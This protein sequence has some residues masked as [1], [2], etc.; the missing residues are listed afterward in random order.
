MKRTIFYIGLLLPLIGVGQANLNLNNLNL[1]NTGCGYYG[2]TSINFTGTTTLVSGS[3][4]DYDFKAGSF[5]KIPAPAHMSMSSPSA[6]GKF[7]ASIS[8]QQL[9]AVILTPADPNAVPK[10]S[11]L[12]IGV[13]IPLLDAKIYEFLSND[14]TGNHKPGTGTY[15]NDFNAGVFINPYDPQQISVD[16]IF[17]KPSSPNTNGIPR[18][19]FYFKDVFDAATPPPNDDWTGPA[20][21]SNYEWR[22]RFAPDEV[23]LWTGYVNVYVG[24]KLLVENKYFSFTVTA[25]LSNLTNGFVQKGPNSRY[26]QYSGTGDTYIPIGCNYSTPMTQDFNDNCASKNCEGVKD[27]RVAHGST[28]ELNHFL[29]QL[30]TYGNS[31]RLLMCPWGLQIEFEKLGNYDTRQIEMSILDK[32]IDQLEQKGVK[33]ILGQIHGDLTTEPDE[34]HFSYHDRWLG[35]PYNGNISVDNTFRNYQYKGIASISKPED[36]F[37]PA[38]GGSATALQFMKNRWRYIESRWG[39]STAISE[40]ELMTEVDNIGTSYWSGNTDANVSNFYGEIARYLKQN[41]QTKHLITASFTGESCRIN[42][43]PGDHA[44]AMWSKP[45]ID[46]VTGHNYMPR[47]DADRL[48]FTFT[49][50]ARIAYPT[51]PVHYDEFDNQNYVRANLC[52]DIG[53]HNRIWSSMFTGMMGPGLP[54]GER[55][56]NLNIYSTDAAASQDPNL[57]KAAHRLYRPKQNYPGEGRVIGTYTGEY[58]KNYRS[59]LTFVSQIDFKASTYNYST[60]LQYPLP[61]YETFM[62]I[63]TNQDKAYGWVHNRSF[64]IYN[65]TQCLCNYQTGGPYGITGYNNMS[66][67]RENPFPD[68]DV[69]SDP[70]YFR[71]C[72]PQAPIASGGKFY[73]QDSYVETT[74][75]VTV[76]GSSYNSVGLDRKIMGIAGLWQNTVY[77]VRW[78]WTWGSN[79]GLLSNY[80]A[81]DLPSPTNLVTTDGSGWLDVLVPP[82]GTVNG[83]AYPG[84]WAVKITRVGTKPTGIDEIQQSKIMASPNPS[85]GTFSLSGVNGALHG[86]AVVKLYDVRGRLLMDKTIQDLEGYQLDMGENLSGVYILKVTIGQEETILRLIKNKE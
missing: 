16:A 71:N 22:I 37:D 19:G 17:F 33:L 46:I 60:L 41:L 36:I 30:T 20:Q 56:F 14:P 3:S 25:P 78:Y 4:G 27:H 8:N 67:M 32:Y 28:V 55:N 42:N 79:G 24:G 15:T 12:E 40:F 45:Y 70:H 52:S 47:P 29:D 23:G 69:A 35:S 18:Y 53:L 82:T 49:R 48:T 2:S 77:D 21:I 6:T 75:H 10:F 64:S 39:Y 86:K 83:T 44:T 76:F 13:S 80:S 68:D 51:K 54:Y 38:N 5:I 58:E 50:D 9:D 73:N 65:N 57:D 11:K 84:D 74:S 31:T 26:L 81:Q 72:S 34:Y 43:V 59:V 66:D 62:M 1:T 61:Y 7:H 63:N 85:S